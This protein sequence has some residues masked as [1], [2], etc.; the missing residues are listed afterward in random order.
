[1]SKARNTTG[2][3]Y[4]TVQG[5]EPLAKRA[6]AVRLPESVDAE[7]RQEIGEDLNDWLR[8]AIIEQWVKH[9]KKTV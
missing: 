3:G 6:V 8:Q 4:F 7:L 5:R 2:R 1:M 9:K